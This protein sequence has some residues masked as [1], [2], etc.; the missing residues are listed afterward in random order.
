MKSKNR[1]AE[2][3][4]LRDVAPT[5]FFTSLI[6]EELNIVFMVLFVGYLF[7]AGAGWAMCK[8]HYGLLPKGESK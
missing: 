5:D 4:S 3:E 8:Q 2:M 7:G 1:I 6:R